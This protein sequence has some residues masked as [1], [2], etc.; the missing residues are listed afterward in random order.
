MR[1]IAIDEI[2]RG[3]RQG[4]QT[5][6]IDLARGAV[7]Y[8]APGKKGTSLNG[9]WKRLKRARVTI[10]A[11]ATDM[12]MPYI[13]A[14]KTHLPKA[15]LVIDH[16]HVVKRYQEKLTELRRDLQREAIDKTQKDVLKGTRWLLLK[17]AENLDAEKNEMARLNEAL[18]LNEP[19]AKAYYLKDSLQQIWKQTDKQ[20]AEKWL[21]QWVREA[22]ASGVQKVMSFSKTVAS[23]RSGILAYYDFNRMSSGPIEGVNNRIKALSRQ[24]YG[25]RDQE[26]FELKIKASHEAKDAFAG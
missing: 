3:K 10:E 5:V 26:F 14:V 11:V 8:T 24:A 22:A 9:F 12:G 15:V 1:R 23:L 19:L 7:V 25:F 16:F 18:L 6:V 17:N 2:Y 21:D 20:A 13:S 4:Y